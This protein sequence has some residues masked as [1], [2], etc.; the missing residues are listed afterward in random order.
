MTKL[1]ELCLER[2]EGAPSTAGRAPKQL[3]EKRGGPALWRSGL[4]LPGR[5]PP[6]L[7]AGLPALAQGF[8]QL[9]PVGCIAAPQALQ[10]LIL[11]LVQD[12]QEVLQLRETE[13]FPLWGAERDMPGLT[14]SP[15]AMPSAPSCL[16]SPGTKVWLCSTV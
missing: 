11:F 8:L 9:L 2:R 12:A 7:A 16:V 14:Q 5:R 6:A 10:L 4:C 13:G 1:W 15:D 3:S